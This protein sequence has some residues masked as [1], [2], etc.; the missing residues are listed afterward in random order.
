[1]HEPVDG[2]ALASPTSKHGY[3]HTVPW[4]EGN[5]GYNEQPV[6]WSFEFEHDVLLVSSVF[7]LCS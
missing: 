3:Q 1:M 2:V 6:T 5:P 7:V 4:D